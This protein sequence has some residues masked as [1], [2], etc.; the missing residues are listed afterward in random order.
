MMM[1][2]DQ[3]GKDDDHDEVDEDMSPSNETDPNVDPS[4]SCT[5]DVPQGPA[6][7]DAIN[8][9]GGD[10]PTIDVDRPIL[11]RTFITTPDHD[12]RAERELRLRVPNSYNNAQPTKMEPLIR[13]KC[14]A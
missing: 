3:H 7:E 6:M 13:F 4:I 5:E 10:L 9:G 2:T 12:G 14:K 1:K 11:G 8:N